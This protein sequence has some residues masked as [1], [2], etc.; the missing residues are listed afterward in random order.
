MGAWHQY[1]SATR[2][3]S[4]RAIIRDK[5]R[6]T[7]G[8][9]PGRVAGQQGPSP[10]RRAISRDKTRADKGYIPEKSRPI[11]SHNPEQGARRR[12]P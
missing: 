10:G 4:I 12:V 1:E 3:G 11:K 9:I 8:H 2:P 6:V 7:E 5:A